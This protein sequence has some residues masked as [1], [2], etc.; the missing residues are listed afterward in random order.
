[1]ITSG[2]EDTGAPELLLEDWLHETRVVG[3]WSD[4]LIISSRW[5]GLYALKRSTSNPRRWF[6]V[7]VIFSAEEQRV[8]RQLAGWPS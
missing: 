3:W 7:Y 8:A 5:H 1:M 2:R 6:A 4:Y